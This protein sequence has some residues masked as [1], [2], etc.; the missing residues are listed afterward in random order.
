MDVAAVAEIVAAVGFALGFLQP[1][2][3]MREPGELDA[4]ARRVAVVLAPALASGPVESSIQ[5]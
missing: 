2:L 1:V 5:E 4:V 3:L